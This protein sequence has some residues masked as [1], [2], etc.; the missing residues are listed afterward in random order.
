MA[1]G[2]NSITWW[3]SYGVVPVH[4]VLPQA[5]RS[6]LSSRTVVGGKR[7]CRCPGWPGFPPALRGV[8]DGE[9]WRVFLEGWS[10]D[11]GRLDGLASWRSRASRLATRSWRSWSCVRSCCP[12]R[13]E[14]WTAGGV[15]SQ[16]W[17]GKGKG[18]GAWSGGG[19]SSIPYP[20]CVHR[21]IRRHCLEQRSGL[22]SSGSAGSGHV[23]RLPT[24]A[25]T[26][27]ERRG[28]PGTRSTDDIPVIAYK[29]GRDHEG[30][31]RLFACTTST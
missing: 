3:V 1:M 19:S 28:A 6:G 21:G 23:S 18:P 13:R 8:A 29:R 4:V 5:H 9:R 24:T 11:G 17:R 30:Y 25:S 16:S 12:V 7:A 10:D 26:S 22:L 20:R 2:G 14:A 31:Y 27:E 15:C